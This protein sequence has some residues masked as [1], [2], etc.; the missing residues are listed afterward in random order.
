M[1]SFRF[2]LFAAA[3]AVL[4]GSVVAKSQ[5]SSD[6]TPQAPAPGHGLGMGPMGSPMM[7]LFAKQ[8]N[9]TDD[10]KTQMKSIM[11]KERPTVQPL[12]QQQHQLDMQLL[13]Y[14]QGGFDQNKVQTIAGQKAQIDAQLIV[15]ETRIAHEMY[16]VLTPDQQ[17]QVKQMV[18]NHQARMHQMNQAPAPPPSEN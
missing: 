13:E 7:G 11:Q 1:K 2:R 8:L 9:L 12:R 5:T 18:A 4:M 15:Q 10:Q 17:T 14:V 3:L 6:A 16:Q